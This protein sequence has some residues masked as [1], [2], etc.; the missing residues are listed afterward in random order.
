MMAVMNY[1]SKETA[2]LCG[3]TPLR[4]MTKKNRKI[5]ILIYTRL[6]TRIKANGRG[7]CCTFPTSNRSPSGRR[8]AVSSCHLT[9]YYYHFCYSLNKD[10]VINNCKRCLRYS[11]L[12]HYNPLTS[13]L[14]N[15]P[16]SFV[17]ML[18]KWK[19]FYFK[20]TSK[21]NFN[22][23]KLSLYFKASTI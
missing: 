14:E 9:L 11:I 1:Y 8:S 10:T 12:F 7:S 22:Y 3:P 23:L 4:K 19:H 13:L 2:I 20:S 21:F 15:R 18:I 17:N 6:T 16:T 5:S